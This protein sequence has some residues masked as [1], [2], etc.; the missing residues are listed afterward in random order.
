MA[1]N[2]LDQKYSTSGIMATNATTFQQERFIVPA[3]GIAIYG[4]LSYRF[5]G[6]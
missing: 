1:N 6:L 4:G 2:L 3:A 5:E